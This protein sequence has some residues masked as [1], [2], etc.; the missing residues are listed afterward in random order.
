[1]LGF[2]LSLRKYLHALFKL[3]HALILTLKCPDPL[4]FQEIELPLDALQPPQ[5]RLY[6]IAIVPAL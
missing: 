4:G 5:Q 3:T 2:G 1:V 6:I